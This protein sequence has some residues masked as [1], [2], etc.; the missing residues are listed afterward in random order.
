MEN[1]GEQIGKGV[2]HRR[3]ERRGGGGRGGVARRSGRA[4]A[5]GRPAR[6]SRFAPTSGVGGVRSGASLGGEVTGGEGGS[7]VGRWLGWACIGIGI[8]FFFLGGPKI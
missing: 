2:R 8:E 1:W 3:R 7:A 4:G 5:A 6:A